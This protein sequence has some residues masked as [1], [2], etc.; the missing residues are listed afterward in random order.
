MLF[1]LQAAMMFAL[2]FMGLATTVT[3][4]M[5]AA[6]WI[7]L[8]FGGNFALFPAATRDFF[9]IKNYGAN[10]AMVFLGYGVAGII[11][12]ILA[13]QMKDLLGDYR[14]AFIVCGILS[15]IAAGSALVIKA[16]HQSRMK[17]IA[18]KKLI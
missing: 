10:Y 1:F 17:T 5:V 9:G 7:G 16:P 4:L 8:M 15:V 14:W 6:A 3:G 11:G 12:P 2:V 18:K 13:G